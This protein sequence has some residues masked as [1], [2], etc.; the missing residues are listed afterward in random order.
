VAPVGARSDRVAALRRRG[1]D[2]LLLPGRGGRGAFGG[3]G[4]ALGGRGGAT[5]LVGG[6]APVGAGAPRTG[7]GGRGGLFAAPPCPGADAVP[8]V[9]PLGIRRA[10]DAMRLGPLAVR[11]I[12]DDLVLEGAPRTRRRRTARAAPFASHRGAR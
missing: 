12:G 10:A 11:P 7:K 5:L 4:R 2:V 9:G 1:A 8:A 3:G 6:G